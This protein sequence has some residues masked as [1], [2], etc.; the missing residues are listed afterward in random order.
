RNWIQ[1]NNPAKCP[2][3]FC[4]F[5]GIVTGLLPHLNR[6]M[7]QWKPIIIFCCTTVSAANK[8]NVVDSWWFWKMDAVTTT[9]CIYFEEFV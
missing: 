3:F 4:C 5:K 6:L 1:V 9:D 7:Q 2:E 8:L